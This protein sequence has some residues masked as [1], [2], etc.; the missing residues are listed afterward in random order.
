[1][2]EKKSNLVSLDDMRALVDKK[3]PVMVIDGVE[4][5]PLLRLPE[6]E[7]RKV[8]E[9]IA[10]G[11]ENSMFEKEIHSSCTKLLTM[12][13]SDKEAAKGLLAAVGD[14]DALLLE[15]VNHYFEVTQVGEAS[16]SQG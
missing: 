8:E 4:F 2:V 7:R 11:R 10:K 1:M 3:Y 16:P 15:L 14:D 12:L 5:R 9:F 13:A 6:G